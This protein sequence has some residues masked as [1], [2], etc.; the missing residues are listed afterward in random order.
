MTTA[1]NIDSIVADAYFPALKDHIIS[2]TGLEFYAD[3]PQALAGHILGRLQTRQLTGCFEYWELLQDERAGEVE[4]DQ[5]IAQL[6]IGET[7]FFRHRE[8]FDALR[9]VALP[10]IL[11]QNR[12]TKRLRVWSA[13]CSTGPEAYSVSIL[14]RRDLGREVEGWKI[15]IVGTD[16]NRLLLTQAAEGRYDEWAFRGTCPELRRECFQQE[17]KSWQIDPRYQEGVTFQYHNLARHSFPSL[18]QNLLAFDLVLCR[19]VLIYFAPAVVERNV[20]QLAECL[21]PTGWLVV[22]HAEH[23]AH[24]ERAF[25]IV[26]CRG[27]TFYRKREPSAPRAAPDGPLLPYYKSMPAQTTPNLSRTDPKP[28]QRAGGDRNTHHQRYA[29]SALASRA[30]MSRRLLPC[31][32]VEQIRGLAD[33]G[34]LDSALQL[35][36][37]LIANAPL[38]PAGYYYQALLLDQVSGHDAAVDA[39]NKAIYLDRNFDLAHYFLGLTQQKLGNASAAAKSYHNVLRLF[40]GRDRS[41]RLPDAEG[42]TIADLEMLTRMHLEALDSV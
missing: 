33:R 21:V 27:A 10:E 14:L 15:S 11:R 31:P 6:T 24:F 25:E 2:S 1:H 16:I 7:Y 41:E 13:G 32:D 3:R 26:N 18:I 28:Q 19:N 38:N 4:L 34:D 12:A 29:S 39:L 40:N 30:C 17:G 37:S 35:C 20:G 8:L 5:L 23:S 36:S 42:M 9:D 22:G